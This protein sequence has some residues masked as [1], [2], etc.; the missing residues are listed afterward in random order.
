MRRKNAAAWV[1]FVF[2]GL[3]GSHFN[4]LCPGRDFCD[5][6]KPNMALADGARLEHYEIVGPLGA[7]GMG[8]VYRAVDSKLRREV[9]LKILPPKF[10]ADPSRLAR[11][12]REAHLLASLNHPNIAA[13]YGLEH[14]DGIRFLVLELVEGPTLAERLKSGPMELAEALRIAAG[15]AEALEAAHEKGVVHRDLKP[16]NVKITPSGKVKVLDFGLA[17]ALGEAEPTQSSGD[18]EAQ[19]TATMQETRAGVVM[20][21][22]AYMS[23]EQAEAKPT[24]KRSDVWSFGVVL[25]EM[26]SGKRCFDGKSTSH[27]IVHLLEDD[28]DWQKLPDSLPAGVKHLLE[29]CLQKD[30]AKRLRDVGD[31]RLQLEAMAQEAGAVSKTARVAAPAR[32]EGSRWLWPAVAGAA[33]LLAVAAVLLWAPWRSQTNLVPIRFEVTDSDKM[34]FF[35]GGAMAVSPD[36]HWM[37]F[38]ATGEDGMARYWVRSLD[39]VESRPLPASEGAYVP[40]A[41]TGDSRYVLFTT[42]GDRRLRKADIQGGPPQTLATELPVGLNGADSNQDGVVIF[43]VAS[44]APL[45][46]VSASGGDTTPVTALAQ[47]ESHRWP[48]F[49]PDGHHF[50]YLR[51]SND[52]N[53]MGIYVGSTDVKPEAQSLK[54]LL[55]TNRQAYYAASPKGGAGHLIF[56]RDT[57]L[58]A[59]PFDPGKMELSGD[60]VPIAEGVDSFPGA[61]YGLFSVSHTGALVYRR[62]GGVKTSLNWV[63]ANGNPAG[64]LGE[65]GEYANPAIS[66][67][68][69]RIAVAK[70]PVQSRDIWIVDVARG[71]ST[72]FT[73]DPARDDFPVWSPDGK[74]IVFASTRSGQ[75]KLYIKPADGSGEER[76]LG[77]QTGTPTSWSKDGRFML[78]T[79]VGPKTANDIWVLPDPGRASPASKPTP[80][81]ATQFSEGFA[82]FSPDGRWIAY[83]SN[84]SSAADV[85]VRP[86]SSDASGGG[87]AKWLVSKS[88]GVYPRWRSDGK[89]LFYSTISLDFMAVDIDTSKGFQAGTP[90]RLFATPPPMLNIDWDIA[91][92]GKRFLFVTT[93]NAGRPEPFTVVL[94][95]E[96]GFN[97]NGR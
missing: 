17:K 91:P 11:F 69:T 46:R 50:L 26:L 84:E 75:A 40:A 35:G 6:I 4:F 47:G 54:R 19:P 73:F 13:I 76:M 20:G 61:F 95:W 18:P 82:Q 12:E 94:N 39:T 89:Q 15:I 77:E 57:T 10:A 30:P 31:L 56:L 48:Q 96:A 90:R 32:R 53:R 81:L 93:P 68:G 21:T 66:P 65:P 1:R 23:P 55:A 22:A 60:P 88:S 7:G 58:M 64:T 67:D 44:P 83:T 8:E 9:A 85:F 42:L 97:R 34:K 92:D 43:G 52:P 63:D 2:L 25:Y 33:A 38:P 86:F 87:G 41:W 45:M 5:R 36:G 78:F 49:L 79:S 29:R 59:Q 51:T 74:N 62:G 71:T 80:F 24:D 14:S 27:I 16:A 3:E 72:R 70:G 28:P 37:V